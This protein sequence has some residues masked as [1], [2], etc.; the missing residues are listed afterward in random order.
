VS[1]DGNSNGDDHHQ[2]P[3][4]RRTLGHMQRLLAAATVVSVASSVSCGKERKG[5]ESKGCGGGSGSSSSKKDDG[6]SGLT[7]T[8]QEV[9]SGNVGYAVVDPMP[10]PA[11]CPGVGKLISAKAK[12]HEE[13]GIPHVTV[14]FSTIKSRPDFKYVQ[15]SS[16]TAWNGTALATK[17]TP[18]ETIVTVR[19]DPTGPYNVDRP[20]L[21]V[22]LHTTCNAGPQQISGM[23]AWPKGPVTAKTIPLVV[24]QEF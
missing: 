20:D 10:N 5:A 16:A 14:T 7:V 24:I 22:T 17:H 4:R 21:R 3:A 23:I 15:D 2:S 1:S 8:E 13:G 12:M 11:Y 6:D 19:L 18:T 9:D